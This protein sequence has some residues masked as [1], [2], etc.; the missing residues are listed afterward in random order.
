MRKQNGRSKRSK[1]RADH[2]FARQDFLEALQEQRKRHTLE[3]R[4][5]P[6][7]NSINVAPS[8]VGGYFFDK[9]TNRVKESNRYVLLSAVQNMSLNVQNHN[10]LLLK[11]SITRG[12]DIQRW[13]L[14]LRHRR[15]MY[16]DV[17]NVCMVDAWYDQLATSSSDAV[18]LVAVTFAPAN[19]LIDQNLCRHQHVEPCHCHKLCWRAINRSA[20]CSVVSLKLIHHS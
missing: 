7:A 16:S 20:G 10:P 11:C 12:R 4:N 17:Q 8:S 18:V 9:S 2:R 19:P 1:K 15:L 5:T 14:R 13:R 3:K 6:G